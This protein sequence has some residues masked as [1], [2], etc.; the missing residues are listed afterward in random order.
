MC[1]YI[2]ICGV[3]ILYRKEVLMDGNFVVKVSQIYVFRRRTCTVHSMGVY[4]F[5]F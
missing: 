4:P 2:R 3:C 5:A 1:M